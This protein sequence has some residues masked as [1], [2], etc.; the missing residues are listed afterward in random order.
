MS[1]DLLAGRLATP[2]PGIGNGFVGGYRVRFDEAGPDG[3]LRT[4]GLLRYAQDI[5]WRHSEAL[6][7]DRRWYQEQD[8]SW[9][10]RAVD[11]EVTGAID[12][13]RVV[14]AETVVTEFRRAWARRRGQ[15]RLADG[16]SVAVAL[17]DWVIVDGRGRLVRIPEVFG[18]YFPS[19]AAES[20]VTRVK[21]STQPDEARRLE[22]RVRPSD[23][24][25]LGHVNNGV[26]L[27][28]FEEALAAG[29]AA[30]LAMGLP[31]RIRLE[32]AAS[33][34]PGDVLEAVSWPSD[35]GWWQRLVRPADGAELAR[36]RIEA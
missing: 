11:L 13:G 7:F 21:P 23:I 12:M 10:V 25:P 29:G 15:F 33:A 20:S 9:V 36:A 35:G 4:A 26:Y 27:D 28:W 31:R 22:L 19:R 3:R 32:Y 17:T 30:D 8:L 1:E 16:T 2:I 14:V 6:G 5:A 34:E 24:D 18:Q